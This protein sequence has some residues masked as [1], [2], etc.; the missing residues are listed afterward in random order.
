LVLGPFEILTNLGL[1]PLLPFGA[2]VFCLLLS[3]GRRSA[4]FLVGGATL[5]TTI[6]QNLLGKFTVFL[7]NFL[8]GRGEC[9]NLG[10]L[11]ICIQPK[12]I[13]EHVAMHFIQLLNDVGR[14][15]D[16]LQD[17]LAFKLINKRQ[18]FLGGR[19]FKSAKEIHEE[20]LVSI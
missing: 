5:G 7:L 16:V 15:C 11:L 8:N 13:N 4:V 14:E 12:T 18:Q 17:P 10:I 2:T 3:S 6:K 19:Q 1:D 20:T 9:H